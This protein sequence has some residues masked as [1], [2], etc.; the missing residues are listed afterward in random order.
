MTS[1][2][3]WLTIIALPSVCLIRDF[4]W[5]YAKRMYYPQTYHHVQEIQKYN[6]QDYRPRYVQRPLLYYTPHL[7]IGRY[8]RILYIADVIPS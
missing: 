4:A 8:S 2:R 3:F 5:K 1:P 6:I 7:L